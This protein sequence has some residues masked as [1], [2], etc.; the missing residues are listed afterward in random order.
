MRE[1]DDVVWKEI[2]IL[3]CEFRAVFPRASCFVS[4]PE[5]NTLLSLV[6]TVTPFSLHPEPIPH[7][8]TVAQLLLCRYTEDL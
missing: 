4:L 2:Q 6:R 5:Q 7:N 8:R 1:C 3:D